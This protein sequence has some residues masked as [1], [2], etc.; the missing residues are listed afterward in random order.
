MA[1]Y[2]VLYWRDI[3]AQVR[4]YAGKKAISRPMPDRFQ[5]EIDRIAMK[6]GLVGSDDYLEQW[7][8]TEK[9]ERPGD[10]EAVLNA[11]L[12]ELETE[13]DERKRKRKT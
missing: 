4:V 5:I 13:Y 8:W 12:Q 2:Q 11:L 7:N 9:R 10:T 6:E 1:I 3:P